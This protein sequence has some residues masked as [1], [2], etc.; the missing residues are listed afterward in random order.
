MK[1]TRISEPDKDSDWDAAAF[2]D[3]EDDEDR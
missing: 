1:C 2:S 3:F